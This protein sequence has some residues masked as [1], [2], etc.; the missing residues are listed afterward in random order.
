M[1]SK[2]HKFVGIVGH[3]QSTD[4]LIKQLRKFIVEVDEM[5]I[6]R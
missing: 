1:N 2:S 5:L 4:F 6:G 3:L